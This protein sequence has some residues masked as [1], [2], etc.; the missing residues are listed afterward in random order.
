[1]NPAKARPRLYVVSLGCAKNQVD[2]EVALGAIEREGGFDLTDR[3][4]TADLLVVN[5]CAFIERAVSESIEA[6]LETA[7]MKRP[8]QRLVVMGCLVQRY[9]EALLRELPEV[10][11]FL[12]TEGPAGL[13]G[14]VRR[15]AAGEGP[16]L[17]L[18]PAG[19]LPLSAPRFLTTPPWRAWLRVAEGCDNRCTYCLIPRIRGP[20]RPVPLPDLVAEARDLEERGVKEL[21]LVAQDL[22]AYR[23]GGSDLA[24]LLRRLLA[25]TGIAWIRLL[26]LHP[27]GINSNL[28]KIIADNPRI[29]PYLDVPVQHASD[30]ILARMGRRYRRRDLDALLGRIREH[31]PEAAL[32]TTVMVGFPG[33]GEDDFEALLEFVERWRFDHLGAFAYSDEEGAPSGALGGKVARDVAARRL[34]RVMSLQAGIAAERNRRRVG[35]VEEVLVEGVSRETD[36]LLEGRTRYQAPDVDGVVY[37][38]AGRAEAGGLVPVKITGAHT[39][40]LVGEIVS[41]TTEDGD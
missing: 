40:D 27:N 36:L 8:G 22:T 4:E 15:L 5:T 16:L 25:E 26:Y 18:A 21:T 31:L 2:T 17:D 39:Y 20:L 33:E 1:M 11:A 38:T 41:G 3:P 13:P 30:R 7:E 12:G 29:C 37:I 19:R 10:D 24:A 14:L 9:G 34:D 23:D 6:V 32:R 28:L 35:R